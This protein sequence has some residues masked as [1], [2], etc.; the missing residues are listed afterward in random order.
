MS[1]VV[2]KGYEIP[3]P[4]SNAAELVALLRENFTRLANHRHSGEDSESLALSDFPNAVQ[5]VT[6]GWQNRNA[7][8]GL[9]TNVISIAPTL[10]VD[11]TQRTV[12]FYINKARVYL[13]YTVL[14]QSQIAVFSNTVIP[15]LYL[16]FS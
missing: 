6:T 16:Y 14:N 10:D 3:L 12:A 7:T 2:N 5:R 11:L 15:E 8:T 13:D 1:E 4:T 9:Y